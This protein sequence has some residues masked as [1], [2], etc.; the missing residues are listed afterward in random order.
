M[1]AFLVPSNRMGAWSE[2]DKMADN[3]NSK[4][5]VIFYSKKF[6]VSVVGLICAFLA[7]KDCIIPE[8]VRDKV[9]ELIMVVVSAYNVSQGAADAASGGKT[10]GAAKRMGTV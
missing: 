1:T 8:N 10:S 2:G 4:I 6:W 5:P 9:I 7:T 3:K